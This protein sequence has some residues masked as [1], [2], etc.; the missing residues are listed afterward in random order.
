[1]GPNASQAAE[2]MERFAVRTGL[3]D[4]D[5]PRRYLWTDAFAVCNFIALHKQ[6]GDSR[7]EALANKLVERVHHVLAPHRDPEHPTA[8]GL[9]IGKPLPERKPDEPFDDEL[10]WERDGQYF[11]YLTKWMDALDRLAKATDRPRLNT[12][13]R[14]LAVTA[15]DAFVYEA[16]GKK[17]MYW[18]MSVDLSRALVPSMGQ[19]DPVDGYVTTLC[20]HANAKETGPDLMPALADYA[21]MIDPRHL[22][23]A[24][25][26]GIGGLLLDAAKLAELVDRSVPSANPRLLTAI[27]LGAQIGLEQFANQRALRRPAEHRLAFR[28]LGLAIGLATIEPLG[29]SILQ[30]YMRLRDQIAM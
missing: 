24:D 20:L 4:Q 28:E 13:A 17:R 18:K 22:A 27:L 11:H 16:G 10:E 26:L 3:T 1:M 9:R 8:A 5:A 2:L 21:S 15:H 14:E 7:Y 29:L 12:W 30:P 23:T 6:S 25:P 19:H